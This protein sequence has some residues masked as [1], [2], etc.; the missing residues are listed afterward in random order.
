MTATETAGA[1]SVI[2]SD[3][4]GTLTQNKMQV[5]SICYSQSC[6]QAEKIKNEIIKQNF[7]LNSTADIISTS[8][9]EINRGSSTECALLKAF[10]KM[11]DIS[12]QAY[13]K[14]Y[15]VISRQ[16]FSSDTKFM[17]STIL[18]SNNKT[19]TLLKGA[20][21]VVLNM[22]E[23]SSLQKTKILEQMSDH[24]KQARRIICL[25]HLEG[26]TPLKSLF[27]MDL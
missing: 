25:A 11:S 1:V 17:S 5:V 3:K 13:R 15:N 12:Y 24:Q 26:E 21:E 2:C 6:S 23:L 4:T 9:K 20:P 8:H 18:L 10:N 14:N 19:R 22:C 16:P 27:M 7:A